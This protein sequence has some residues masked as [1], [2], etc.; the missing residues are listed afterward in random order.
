M[1]G[2]EEVSFSSTMR[3]RMVEG[4]PAHLKSF[5]FTLFFFVPGFRF[6]D[7]AAQLHELNVMGL[8]GLHSVRG[9]GQH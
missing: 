7:A 9:Q 6:G 8:V 3:Y 2:T 5:V 4:T 1:E